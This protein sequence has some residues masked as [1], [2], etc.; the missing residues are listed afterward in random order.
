M[1]KIYGIILIMFH[2][3]FIA[4]IMIDFFRFHI[5]LILTLSLDPRLLKCSVIQ[6]LLADVWYTKKIPDIGALL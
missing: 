3:V 5:R 4:T 6:N 2:I 1:E